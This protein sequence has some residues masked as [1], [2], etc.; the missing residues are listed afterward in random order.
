MA[1]QSSRKLPIGWIML[2]VLFLLLLV[3]FVIFR[4]RKNKTK[5]QEQINETTEDPELMTP[6]KFYE[7]VSD[8]LPELSDEARMIITAHAMHE[9]GVFSSRVF[10]EDNN[11]FGMHYPEKRETTAIAQDEKG[12]SVYDTVSSSVDDLKLWF[13]FHNENMEFS[14]P[15]SYAAKIREYEYYTD[16]YATYAASMKIH[17]ESLK[18]LIK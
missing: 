11:A 16:S 15:A 7:L 3:L 17:Y 10:I 4:Y 6:V 2:G 5:S 8:R 12:F 9:T 14:R 13:D 1:E 18:R